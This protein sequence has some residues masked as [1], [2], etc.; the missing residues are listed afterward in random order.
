METPTPVQTSAPPFRASESV[1]SAV[2]WPAIF[3]GAA[4]AA[5]ITLALLPLASTLGFASEA[6]WNLGPD[7]AIEFTTAA[8]VFLV[9]AQWLSSFAGGYVAGRLRTRWTDV[10]TDEVFFRDTAHGLISWCV[11]T[12]AVIVI[13]G[14]AGAVAPEVVAEATQSVA[15]DAGADTEGT[16]MAFSA[17]LSISMFVGALIAS[18]SAVIGGKQRDA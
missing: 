5:G 12:F 2:Y 18:V 15:N 13:A 11:A 4:V 14:G 3:A 10:R 1:D 16:G 7:D 9:V 6:L 17:A 8:A